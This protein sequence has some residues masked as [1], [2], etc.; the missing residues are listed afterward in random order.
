MKTIVHCV[1]EELFYEPM[2]NSVVFITAGDAL[3]S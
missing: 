2:V 1:G 3:F